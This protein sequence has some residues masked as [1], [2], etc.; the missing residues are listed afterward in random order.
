MGSIEDKEKNKMHLVQ[1]EAHQRSFHGVVG[2]LAPMR[3]LTL[4]PSQGSS[5]PGL[6]WN[7]K[8]RTRSECWRKGRLKGVV[9][10]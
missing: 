9:W 6:A 10:T 7:V 1:A 3:V 2:S 4:R 5:F 8:R